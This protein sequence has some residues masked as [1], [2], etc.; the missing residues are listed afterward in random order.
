MTRDPAS[1][2]DD[3]NFKLLVMQSIR[4]VLINFSH[5]PLK[6]WSTEGVPTLAG[7]TGVVHIKE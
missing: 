3:Q 5:G 7:H 2:D 4:L 1:S 6:V